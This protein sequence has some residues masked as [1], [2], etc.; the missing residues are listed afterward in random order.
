MSKER[1]ETGT[2]SEGMSDDKFATMIER[3]VDPSTPPVD[4][5]IVPE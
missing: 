4:P 2:G 5:S 1:S 3:A